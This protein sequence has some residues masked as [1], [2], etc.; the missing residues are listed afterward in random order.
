M[1][2]SGSGSIRTGTFDVDCSSFFTDMLGSNGIVA[3]GTTGNETGGGTEVVA[4]STLICIFR[5]AGGGDLERLRLLWEDS[6]SE[7]EGFRVVFR[8]GAG[9]DEDD[10]E[11]DFLRRRSLRKPRDRDDREPDRDRRLLYLE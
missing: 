10:A 4:A 9:E 1:G 3:G 8:T 6:E 5:A 11:D 7:M 2:I